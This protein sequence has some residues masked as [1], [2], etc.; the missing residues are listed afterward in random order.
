MTAVKYSQDQDQVNK[1]LK[2]GILSRE[3]EK[4][5]VQTDSEIPPAIWTIYNLIIIT[6]EPQGIALIATYILLLP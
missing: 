4:Y 5:R 1:S 6:F 3:Q 2:G